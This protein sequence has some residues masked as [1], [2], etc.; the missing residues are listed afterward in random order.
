M[1]RPARDHRDPRPGRVFASADQPAA[2]L[3]VSR[4]ARP[5]KSRDALNVQ[6]RGCAIT[7]KLNEIYGT[8]GED[9][10]LPNDARVLQAR[11]LAKE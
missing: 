8:Q 3:Q 1:S 7:A 10:S 4:S 11:S 9:S 5:V 6:H 2:R